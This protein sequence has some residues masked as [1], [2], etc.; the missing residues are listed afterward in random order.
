MLT[1]VFARAAQRA[2]VWCLLIAAPVYAVTSSVAQVTGSAHARRA[3]L[4]SEPL[5]LALDWQRTI[6]ND[7]SALRQAM[8]ARQCHL[9]TL[10]VDVALDA[11]V[12]D[13]LGD[14]SPDAA[15]ALGFALVPVM[16]I[17]PLAPAMAPPCDS[18]AIAVLT[19]EG[20]RLDRP[21]KA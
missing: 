8:V 12:F 6:G 10:A 16:P 11:A 9:P 2:V 15:S 3:L 18:G 7:V 20:T 5:A 21:P 19:R 14:D 1:S 4:Q 17:E 13:T